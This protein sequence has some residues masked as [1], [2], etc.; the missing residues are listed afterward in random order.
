[1]LKLKDAVFSKP[2]FGKVAEYEL[3]KKVSEWNEEILKQFYSDVNYL[4]K[5]LGVD[6]VVDNVDENKGYAKGSIVVF[7]EGKKI[8]F[9]V[10][11]KDFMLSPFD[12][13]IYKEGDKIMYFEANKRNIG[14]AL[15]T[16]T[17]GKLENI[18]GKGEVYAGV[19]PTGGVYPKK[20]VPLD[21]TT[22]DDLN[23]TFSKISSWHKL[24][25][26]E[27]LEK[28]AI[29]ME[30]EPD[31]AS[32][33]VDNTGDLIGNVIRLKDDES[34]VVAD[35]HKEGDLNMND[36]VKAKRVVT[37]IDSELIDTAS[38]KPISPPS[39]AELRMYV[40]PSMEDFLERGS[41]MAGRFQAS[42]VGRPLSGIVLDCKDDHSYDTVSY[43]DGDSEEKKSRNSRPQIFL[44]LC[45]CYY[46]H[47]SDYGKTGIA[48]YG[49]RTLDAEGAM[50][51]AV[52]RLSENVT[53]QFLNHSKDNRRD[54]AD[55]SFSANNEM[56]QGL[57]GDRSDA[58]SFDAMTKIVAI[59]GA[60][61]AWEAMRFSGNFKKYE[62]NNS[63]VYA[64]NTKAI[65]P[66][67][68]ATVQKVSSVQD[69]VYKMIVGKAKD[70]YLVPEGT[71]FFNTEYMHEVNHEDFMTPDIPVKKMF[72]ES[73][74]KKVAVH[75][76]PNGYS[77]GYRITGRPFESLKK[78]A[79][80][81][82]SLNTKQTISALQIMG[83]DKT[84]AQ[85][86][87]KV[88]MNRYSDPGRSDKGVVVYGVNDD[89][90][91]KE[92]FSGREKTARV[93]SIIKEYAYSL[94]KDL[95]K[96]ASVIGDSDAV[97]VVLSL[98]FINEDSIQKYV[99]NIQEM[100]RVSND[101]SGMLIASRMG[102]T[103]I[104]ENAL[105]KSI[106]GINDVIE[107]LENLKMATSEKSEG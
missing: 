95:V 9:P 71:L 81:N 94:R 14:Q 12:T 46:S 74:M 34:R 36:V 20:S 49:T 1:M 6:I 73:N 53:D 67:N 63:S 100:K 82:G 80:I 54:G 24:A 62:V 45:G 47:C 16:E 27:D 92:I 56:T 79:S 4:P 3:P 106:A 104:D 85:E 29:Q 77:L 50:E 96:E 44:S 23:T 91:N 72:E 17:T 75:V 31:V 41:D 55:K 93:N 48:F 103:D 35:D 64:S 68:V 90:I 65:I 57:D 40:Y 66:A 60:G 32:S 102:L 78:I 76:S 37:A 52:E 61:N 19:K 30:A 89:Y 98:N 83:M 84:A 15:S 2:T 7:S 59:Y 8:N 26:K 107:G 13:F 25:K 33:F 105:R 97:D 21:D 5:S 11:V 43:S 69:P 51:K 28:L 101:L 10:I 18:W 38:L 42:K 22:T 88:A 70:I 87:L 58:P 39:V 86:T 99:D